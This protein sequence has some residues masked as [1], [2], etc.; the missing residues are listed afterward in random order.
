MRKV[1]CII[2]FLFALVLSPLAY[3][4][5][6][7]VQALSFGSFVIKNNDAQYDIIIH[8]GGAYSFSGAGFL[9]ITPPQYGIYDIDGLPANS[10]ISSINISQIIPLSNSGESLQMVNFEENHDN[11]NGAG[12]AQVRIGATARTSGNGNPY[13]DQTYTGQ[14]QIQIN[15]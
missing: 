4:G 1:L 3:A 2:F 8:P 15:F 11:S 12:V 13:L 6:T 10:V 9:E 7:T 14:L 5:V